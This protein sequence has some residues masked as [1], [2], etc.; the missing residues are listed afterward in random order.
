MFPGYCSSI[1]PQRRGDLLERQNGQTLRIRDRF[2][3]K[4]P[5]PW[6]SVSWCFSA[7]DRSENI[8]SAPTHKGSICA[9]MISPEVHT[10]SFCEFTHMTRWPKLLRCQSRGHLQLVSLNSEPLERSHKG[11]REVPARAPCPHST[12]GSFKTQKASLTPERCPSI[13]SF[14]RCSEFSL[15][16]EPAVKRVDVSIVF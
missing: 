15:L 2:G 16:S 6:T 7:L 14:P 10:K 3:I 5:S 13:C 4:T 9:L 12:R 11:S 8:C 1:W